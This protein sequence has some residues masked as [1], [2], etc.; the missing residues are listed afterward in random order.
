MLGCAFIIHCIDDYYTIVDL[1]QQ[2]WH[3]WAPRLWHQRAPSRHTSGH[4]TGT[5]ATAA[6][7][8]YQAPGHQQAPRPEHQRAPVIVACV[9]SLSL[10][11]RVLGLSLRTRVLSRVFV[12]VQS[13]LWRETVGKDSE[14]VEEGDGGKRDRACCGGIMCESCTFSA[15]VCACCL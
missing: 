6:N 8:E 10:R 14:L 4:Q 15:A 5:G 3:P 11:T 13:L 9:L 2:L 1:K 7:R 12:R